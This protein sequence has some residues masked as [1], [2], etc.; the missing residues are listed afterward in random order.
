MLHK[1]HDGRLLLNV[2]LGSATGQANGDLLS[3]IQFS[4]WVQIHCPILPSISKSSAT[5]NMVFLVLY[6]KA[7]QAPKVSSVLREQ[8]KGAPN[9]ISQRFLKITPPEEYEIFRPLFG[10]HV[11]LEMMLIQFVLVAQQIVFHQR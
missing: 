3:T 1:V 11:L 9:H 2:D 7:I 6:A 4:H 5:C 10:R 8:L